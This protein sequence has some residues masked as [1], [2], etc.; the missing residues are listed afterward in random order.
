L[1]GDF[2]GLRAMAVTL[3]PRRASSAVMR[4]PTLPDAPMMAIFMEVSFWIREYGIQ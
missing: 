3:W 1:P 2:S 4:E